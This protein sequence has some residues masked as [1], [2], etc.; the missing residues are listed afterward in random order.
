LARWRTGDT[1]GVGDGFLKKI[2]IDRSTAHRWS[3]SLDPLEN[4]QLYKQ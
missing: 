1:D 4:D 3:Y 2:G